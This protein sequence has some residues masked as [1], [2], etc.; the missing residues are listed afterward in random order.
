MEHLGL[1]DYERC[2]DELRRVPIEKPSNMK[3]SVRNVVDRTKYLY[4]PERGR[5]ALTMAGETF[6]KSLIKKET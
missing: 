1:D 3:S 5:F 4:N 2:Y 6:V